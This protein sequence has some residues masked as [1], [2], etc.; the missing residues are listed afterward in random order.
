MVRCCGSLVLTGAMR[1]TQGEPL[2]NGTGTIDH[3]ARVNEQPCAFAERPEETI[4]MRNLDTYGVA[5]LDLEPPVWIAFV[6]W[7]RS[8]ARLCGAKHRNAV[9]VRPGT[10]VYLQPD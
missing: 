5:S 10:L 4:T 1:L 3:V 9:S 6:S 2:D 7:R 8:S